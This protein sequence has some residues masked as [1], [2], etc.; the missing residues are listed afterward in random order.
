MVL[1]AMNHTSQQTIPMGYIDVISLTT[2]QKHDSHMLANYPN[3]RIVMAPHGSSRVD[4]H[5]EQL[6]IQRGIIGR[7]RLRRQVRCH[8]DLEGEGHFVI[9]LVASLQL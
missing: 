5:G 4:Q 9:E 2:A 6:I 1:S 7:P 3:V 8:I